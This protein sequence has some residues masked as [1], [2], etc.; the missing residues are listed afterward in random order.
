MLTPDYSLT[1]YLV[2]Y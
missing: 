1:M 2:L